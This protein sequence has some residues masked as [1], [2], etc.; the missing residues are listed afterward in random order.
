MVQCCLIKLKSHKKTA[1]IYFLKQYSNAKYYTNQTTC[2]ENLTQI[3]TMIHFCLNYN[4]IFDENQI[5]F[6]RL[7]F[8]VSF[9]VNFAKIFKHFLFQSASLLSLF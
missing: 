2:Q 5:Y 3:F 9:L 4:I 7:S 6:F 1:Q 8:L